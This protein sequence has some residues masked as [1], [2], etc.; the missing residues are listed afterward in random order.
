MVQRCNHIRH[1]R[2]DNDEV[3]VRGFSLGINA[4]TT[5][6]YL[7]ETPKHLMAIAASKNTAALGNVSSATAKKDALLCGALGAQR[8]RR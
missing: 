7:I 8:L 3:A 1:E 6:Q 2:L 5:V 4:S